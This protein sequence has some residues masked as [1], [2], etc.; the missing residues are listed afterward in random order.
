[1]DLNGEAMREA[2]IRWPHINFVGGNV[3]EH[4]L[5]ANSFD[6]VVSMQVIAHVEDQAAFIEK[7]VELLRPGGYI[8]LSTNNKFVMDRLGNNDWGNRRS[9]GHIEK[10]PSVRSL[11][12]LE[13]TRFH[14]LQTSTLLAI[15]DG[16]V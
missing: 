8:M 13:S 11:K 14:E 1:M 15:A 9:A 12:R 6:V 3:F 5:E 7:S 4:P 2:G 10:W 16:R